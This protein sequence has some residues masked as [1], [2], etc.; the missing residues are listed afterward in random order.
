V[1]P[2]AG[3]GWPPL[4]PNTD[5]LVGGPSFNGMFQDILPDNLHAVAITLAADY[6]IGDLLG[7]RGLPAS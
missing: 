4:P 3:V 2:S 7:I 6:E 5:L 1:R